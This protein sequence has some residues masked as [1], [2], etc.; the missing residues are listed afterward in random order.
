MTVPHLPTVPD[1]LDYWATHTPD[2]PAMT[3][4]GATVSYAELKRDVDEVA[5]ALLA[6]GIRKGDRIA[7]LTHPNPHFWL[8]FLASLSIGGVWLGLNPKYKLPELEYNVGNSRP[9]LL[10]GIGEYGDDDFAPAL[11]TLAASVD[12]PPP[13]LFGAESSDGSSTARP[14]FDAWGD[15]LARG[16][17]VTDEELA[18]ARSEVDA[19]SPALIVYT[20][21]STGRPKGAVLGHGGIARSFEIQAHRSPV[22]RIR[23]IANLPVN[24]IGGVGDL[25]C[26]PLVQGG[27]I[28]F[29]E[30]FDPRAMIDAVERLGVNSFMQIPTTLKILAE[31][32]AFPAA[33]LSGLRYVSWGGG[34]LPLRVVRRFRELGV[35]MSTTFGMTEITGSVS[36]SADD[37][38]DEQLADTVGRPIEQIDFRLVDEYGDVV[39]KGSHGEIQVRHPG[40]LLEYFDNPQATRDAFTD[41]GYFSTGDVGYVRDDGNLCLVAR[42]KEIFKSGGYNTYPREIELVLEEHPAVRSASVVPAPHPIFDEVG[43]AYVEVAGT[44]ATEEALTDWC[45]GR[46]A[47]YKVPKRI[48]ALDALPLLPVGKV[49]KMALR[50][51]AAEHVAPQFAGAR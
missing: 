3:H 14:G 26:T 46:L 44:D 6:A 41:D 24:H 18:A 15:F 34:P 39:A 22:E 51:S 40:L 20:S 48:I 11:E 7:V 38:T 2:A 4:R 12:A 32:P 19:H 9:S 13:I 25:C 17:R 21:G 5:R 43:V 1:Y 29:Q 28:V 33:D 36:Y 37:A 45:R 10:L 47:N 30:Q 50:R 31:H 35:H 16:S 27:S 49:D 8:T 42:T 23:G